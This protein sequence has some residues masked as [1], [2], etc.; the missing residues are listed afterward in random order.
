MKKNG[1][2]SNKQNKLRLNFILLFWKM[3]TVVSNFLMKTFSSCVCQFVI[4]DNFFFSLIVQYIIFQLLLDSSLNICTLSSSAPGIRGDSYMD[5]QKLMVHNYVPDQKVNFNFYL[6]I[7]FSLRFYFIRTV[8][9]TL[10]Y[11]L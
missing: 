4:M 6:L 10:S 8:H 3:V 11:K 5:Q 2:V 9:D 1:S 7:F